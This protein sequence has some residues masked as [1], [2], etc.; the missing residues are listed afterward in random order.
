MSEIDTEILNSFAEESKQLVEECVGILE[1]VEGHPEQA[2]LLENFSNRID[3]IMG[4]AKSLAPQDEGHALHVI[5]QCA[6]LCKILGYR[7]S[8]LAHHPQ[9][10]NTTVSF[11]LDATE[12][13]GELLNRVNEPAVVLRASVKDVLVDRLKW[14]L[15][16]VVVPAATPDAKASESLRQKEIDELMK[17]LGM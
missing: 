9:L 15:E 1:R 14:V 12:H 6:D 16:L 5:G 17:K 7:A 2:V 3:R 8:K 13:V 4:A 10:F 11:L